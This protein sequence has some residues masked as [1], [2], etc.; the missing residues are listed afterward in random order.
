MDL[1]AK[2]QLAIFYSD[3]GDC[4]ARRIQLVEH[5][6]IQPIQLP[7]HRPYSYA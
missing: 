3:T 2:G 5:E 1:D 4:S 7:R 6:G